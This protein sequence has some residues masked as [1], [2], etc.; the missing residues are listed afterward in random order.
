MSKRKPKYFSDCTKPRRW[1]VRH[2][3]LS[4]GTG[5]LGPSD[6]PSEWVEGPCGTPLFGDEERAS[7]LCRACASG[8]TDPENY[9]LPEE[10]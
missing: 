4:L 3:T 6:K 8:W 1:L 10:P 2:S 9:P 7:G 5:E